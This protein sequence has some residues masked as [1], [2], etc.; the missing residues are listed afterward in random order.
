LRPCPNQNVSEIVPDAQ[1]TL[2]MVSSL[3]EN[4]PGDVHRSL[5]VTLQGGPKST[6]AVESVIGVP[7]GAA[8]TPT[9]M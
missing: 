4:V 9:V 8:V 7:N 3:A 1:I 5:A 2:A 6:I